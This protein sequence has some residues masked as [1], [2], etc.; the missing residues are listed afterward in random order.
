[1][2]KSRLIIMDIIIVILVVLN[3]AMIIAVTENYNDENRTY[4]TRWF[5]NL[6]KN[7]EYGRAVDYASRDKIVIDNIQDNEL[8]E[9]IAVAEY[10]NA[11]FYK[12][13]YKT[14]GNTQKLKQMEEQSDMALKRM[15]SLSILKQ[16]IDSIVNVPDRQTK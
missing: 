12:N 2:K 5:M 1:M 9:S 11:E 7:D 15:G 4:N 6:Y 14:M 3:A 13:V 16:K 10:Y 8:D